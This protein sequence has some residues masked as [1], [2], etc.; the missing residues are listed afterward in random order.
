MIAVFPFISGN[1]TAVDA[2][3]LELFV[4]QDPG[5]AALF[6]VDHADR[7]GGKAPDPVDLSGIPPSGVNS[8]LPAQQPDHH[9]RHT[10]QQP[11]DER[12]IVSPRL[13]I[14][15]MGGGNIRRSLIELMQ[16]VVRARV[17]P[18]DRNRPRHH[19]H[20]V[21]NDVQ[22][23]VLTAQNDASVCRR[24]ALFPVL[25]P[26]Q[27]FLQ[28]RTVDSQLLANLHRRDLPPFD[29]LIYGGFLHL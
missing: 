2:Q 22:A 8:H 24:T 21:G 20:M 18:Q 28:V 11:R 23:V 13:L 14:P 6:P 1:Q 26:P 17:A 15:E 29:H 16:T 12:K 25:L 27:L 10:R 3:R 9:H 4:Q 7:A 5:P 19:S